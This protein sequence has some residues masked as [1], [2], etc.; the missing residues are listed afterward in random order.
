MSPRWSNGVDPDTAVRM[1]R[2]QKILTVG[3][4][5]G[6]SSS[7]RSEA[8]ATSNSDAA[9]PVGDMSRIHSS[10]T[11]ETAANGSL[12]RGSGSPEAQVGHTLHLP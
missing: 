6:V 7:V 4:E 11:C 10:P 8:I 3:H 9:A 12:R 1:G 2:G 5:E